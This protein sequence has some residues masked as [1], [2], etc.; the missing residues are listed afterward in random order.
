M[1]RK[2]EL[3][4][5]KLFARAGFRLARFFLQSRIRRVRGLDFCVRILRAQ[6]FLSACGPLI[7]AQNSSP[8][9]TIEPLRVRSRELFRTSRTVS[10][11][12]NAHLTTL[13]VLKVQFWSFLAGFCRKLTSFGAGLRKGLATRPQKQKRGTPAH[14][15]TWPPRWS[16]RHRG[17]RIQGLVKSPS[18]G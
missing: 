17:A 15:V 16:T 9:A 11:R 13:D 6:S 5:F 10:N 8:D 4:A 2:T 14:R 1:D 7:C 3:G 18:K 12:N